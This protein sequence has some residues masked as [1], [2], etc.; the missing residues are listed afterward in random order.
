M[1]EIDPVRLVV[2]DERRVATDLL[3]RYGRSRGLPGR[4]LTD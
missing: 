4:L 2:L 3:R 1:A